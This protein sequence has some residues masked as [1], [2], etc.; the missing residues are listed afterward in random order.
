MQTPTFLQKARLARPTWEAILSFLVLF[1]SLG[2]VTNVYA[3]FSPGQSTASVRD[4]TITAGTNSSSANTSNYDA[5]ATGGGT[6]IGGGKFAGTNFG[7]LDVNDGRLLLQEGTV[8]IE[9]VAGEVYSRAFIQYA[10]NQGTISST[11]PP[12]LATQTIELTETGYTAGTTAGTGIRVF[13]ISNAARNIL[14]LA[15]VTG[16]S[17]RFDI[18]VGA[19]GT[20]GSNNDIAVFG[21]RRRSV[22]TPTGT[23][24]TAT[25]VTNNVLIAPDGNSASPYY[26]PNTGTTPQFPGAVFTSSTNAGGVAGAFNVNNG[27]LRLINTSV[28]TSETGA[29]TIQSVVLYYRTRVTGTGGGAF[30]PIT[31]TQS[32]SANAG[33]R[34]FVIDPASTINTN[35]QPNLVATPVVTTAGNYSVDIYYQANGYNS[36]TNATFSITYPPSGS[37]SPFTAT[38]AVA[39]TPIATTIWTGAFNDNWFD[40]SNWSA[41]V[42]TAMTNALVRDLGAG[43]SVPYPNINSDDIKYT[44]SG[45]VLY[46]N[47]GSGPA[48]AFNLIMGGST[49][50]S[51]SITRLEK[52]QL[53]IYGTFDNTYDSFIQREN[54]IMEFAGVNQTITGG[55]FLRVDIS[56]GGIKM[57]NGI[58]NISETINFLTPTV[59]AYNTVSAN[60]Y[61]TLD[62]NAGVLATDI[63]Q[64]N[65][66][67]V[68]LADRAVINSNNGAQING[69][70]DASY[71]HGF[72]RTSRANVLVNETRTY[73]NMGMTL[74]FTGTNAPGNVEITRNTVE[75]Y[76]PLNTRYG[77]RRIFGVRPS[78]PQTT[79]GGL[80]AT[81]IFRYRDSETQNLGGP[82]TTSYGTGSIAED[83]LTIFASSNSGNTFTLIGRD[84]VN[85][86]TN[87]VTRAGVTTFATITMGDVTNP[88]PVSLVSFSATREGANARL[89]WATASERNNKGFEVQVSMDGKIFRTLNFMASQGTNSTT[90]LDY[91]YTDTE[92]GKTGVRYYRLY[93]LDIDGQTS[94]S[95]IRAVSFAAATGSAVAA[96]SSYP[97]PF[98]ANDQAALVLQAPS[99]GTARL[100]VMDL[101]GRTLLNREITTVA[102]ISELAVPNAGTLATGVY[103]VKVTFATGEVKT[104]RIQKL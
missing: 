4:V 80:T 43:N 14:A 77:I 40:A 100:Q 21:A 64:P 89:V 10:V 7:A 12:F 81:M 19:E 66:S 23:P 75:S 52:G 59:N 71:L 47:T 31:L 79:A 26:F 62:A 70:T 57:L 63:T 42:P 103:L 39:G 18:S 74:T 3:Q 86:T 16:T 37:A 38:F 82:T 69:E 6:G 11:N 17:Y 104:L 54:T 91:T 68:V 28:T 55:S 96:V 48:K 35:A 9:E 94:Y 30:Q 58:M 33:V 51:R 99:A 41:G 32:G 84:A 29:N 36:S 88:L 78:D 85:T 49:Q 8:Q 34:T 67:V 87:E 27:Q 53:Q 83:N 25:I 24:S 13:S 50:A 15:T 92:T 20:D 45:A 1:T 101:S 72:I 102:G 97:N 65:V 60:P 93:Q 46:N 61:T 98:N 2:S 5:I 44:A 56:G 22:F 76:S 95:P 90:K 73:G